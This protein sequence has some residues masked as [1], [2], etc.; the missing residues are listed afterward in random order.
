MLIYQLCHSRNAA[1]PENK[2]WKGSTHVQ[3]KQ[4]MERARPARKTSTRTRA[5]SHCINISTNCPLLT[6]QPSHYLSGPGWVTTAKQANLW[7]E[8]RH[9]LLTNERSWKGNR[10]SKARGCVKP[11]RIYRRPVNYAP[12]WTE[13]VMRRPRRS[14]CA[15]ADLRA[16]R[17]APLFTHDPQFGASVQSSGAHFPAR[18]RWE[19][20]PMTGAH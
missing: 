11:C 6:G 9:Q 16:A 8:S 15:T 10:L 1:E 20:A 18:R 5:R 3:N 13:A 14:S 2:P 4:C 19:K 12:A 7:A 17:R